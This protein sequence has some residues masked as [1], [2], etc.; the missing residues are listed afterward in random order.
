MTSASPVELLV[1]TKCRLAGQDPAP[2]AA[3]RPG[4]G[5]F[6]AL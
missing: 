1:C 4:A 5:L 2:E 6:E 3:D